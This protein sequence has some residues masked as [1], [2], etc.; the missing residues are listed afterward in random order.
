MPQCF[1]RQLSISWFSGQRQSQN[2]PLE[3]WCLVFAGNWGMVVSVQCKTVRWLG[4]IWTIIQSQQPNNLQPRLQAN[5]RATRKPWAMLSRF[6]PHIRHY[7]WQT[8]CC[9]CDTIH[10]QCQC[11]CWCWYCQIKVYD[12][13]RNFVKW[14]DEQLRQKPWTVAV[15]R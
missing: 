11:P 1:Q 2:M 5:P 10:C 13:N 14:W 9:V 15:R 12:S 8:T 7:F 4:Q 6:Q 3:M